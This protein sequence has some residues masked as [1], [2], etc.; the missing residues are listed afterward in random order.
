[1]G[2][3]SALPAPPALAADGGDAAAAADANPLSGVRV[4]LRVAWPLGAVIPPADVERYA[5]AMAALLA[6]R[7]AASALDA[8]SASRRR[9]A[10]AAGGDHGTKPL[11][12]QLALAVAEAALFVKALEEHLATRV[13]APAKATLD[14]ALDAAAD[15]DGVRAAHAAFLAA[16]CRGTLVAPDALWTLLAPR[17][18]RL[19]ALSLRLA[20][21]ARDGGSA[22]A[23]A[24]AAAC[25]A[26]VRA[27]LRTLA[28][29]LRAGGPAQQMADCEGLLARLDFNGYFTATAE[30]E[31]TAAA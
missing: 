14:A 2:R 23:E 15:L 13:L 27:T 19:L 1:V 30:A 3:V 20:A 18:R 10:A 6:V 22:T 8:V 4:S 12:P 28:Q 25:R 11:P 9:S 26:E 17:V 16:V 5:R 24:D 21:A 31:E 7:R 29:K